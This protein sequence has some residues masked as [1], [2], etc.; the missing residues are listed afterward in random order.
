MS[1]WSNRE[2][3]P[4]RKN[5][6]YVTMGT[7]GK[8]Y[9]VSSVSKPSVT[10]ESKEYQMINHFYK[11]PGIPKWENISVKFVDAKLWGNGTSTVGG[12]AVESNPRST[13]KTLWEMLLAS[14]YVTP[15]E[16]S[17]A[18]GSLAKVVSP[19]KAAMIDLSFGSSPDKAY[20]DSFKIHQVNAKGDPTEIWTLY[21]PMITKISWGDLDYGSNDLV[22]YTLDV[23]YDWAQLEEKD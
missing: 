20:R 9:S 23:A 2:V 19:E 3:E 8:L 14:G 4:K 17:S 6:F 1:W 7:G 22:E 18:I 21:N 5:K 12:S 16:I 11:Y 15:N 10:I 13:S